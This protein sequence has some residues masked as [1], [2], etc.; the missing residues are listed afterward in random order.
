MATE[1]I[2]LNKELEKWLKELMPKMSEE[3]LK[4]IQESPDLV[5]NAVIEAYK[6]ICEEKGIDYT[7]TAMYQEELKYRQ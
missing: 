7:Q 5:I 6:Q 1:K 3:Q 2:N 4:A